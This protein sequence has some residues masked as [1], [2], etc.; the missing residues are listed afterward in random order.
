MLPRSLIALSIAPSAQAWLVHASKARVLHLFKH[1][2]NLVNENGEVL[3]IVGSE[4]GEG[5]FNILL[6]DLEF[7]FL[8]YLNV[9]TP[10]ITRSNY[11]SLGNINIDTHHAKTWS[12]NLDW[13]QLHTARNHICLQLLNLD[14]WLR[15][16][17][18]TNSTIEYLETLLEI[19]G[20]EDKSQEL[21]GASSRPERI[22]TPPAFM[23]RANYPKMESTIQIQNS[24][25]SGFILYAAQPIKDLSYSIVDADIRACR[26][27]VQSLAGLGPGLT[28]AGDDFILG[29]MLASRIIHPPELGSCLTEKIAEAACQLTTSLSGAWLRAAGRGEAGILWHHFLATLVS[30]EWS[31]LKN[32]T[33]KLLSVGYTSGADSLAGFLT[34]FLL[35]MSQRTDQ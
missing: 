26:N 8:N 28:P 32:F 10:I 5:P 33:N 25:E 23:E 17:A 20:V 12:P 9:E 18:P 24:A 15:R 34:P 22:S 16:Q 3:S 2:C 11:I 29:A 7:S 35:F 21:R 14:E 1:A 27:A 31:T 19:A 6:K 4:I 30:G 13:N